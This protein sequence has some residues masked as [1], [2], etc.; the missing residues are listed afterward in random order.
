MFF[1]FSCCDA[2]QEFIIFGA[3]SG[4]LYIFKRLINA[5][6]F[7]KIIPN[8]FG[9]INSVAIERK[10][11]TFIAFST[12]KGYVIITSIDANPQ[13][14]ANESN[15]DLVTCLYWADDDQL[16][17]GNI[18]GQITLINLAFYMVRF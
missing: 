8:K 12:I 13:I 11:E 17:F 5:A 15:K 3:T 6:Q 2:S 18:R 4:S 9:S 7:V 14:V 1:K 16:F 10:T